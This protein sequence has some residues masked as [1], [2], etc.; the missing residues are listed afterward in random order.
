[1]KSLLRSGWVV[2][3]GCGIGRTCRATFQTTALL[4]EKEQNPTWQAT[5]SAA[6]NSLGC[7]AGASPS[8][9]NRLLSHT[10]LISALTTIRKHI[11]C[12]FCFRLCLDHE[13]RVFFKHI[14]WHALINVD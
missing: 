11:K 4:Q 5:Y 6:A 8:S 12:M 13:N 2:G 3:M 9:W 7:S 14:S 10:D 1:M